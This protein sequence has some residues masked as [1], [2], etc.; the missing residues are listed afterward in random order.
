MEIQRPVLLSSEVVAM[1]PRGELKRIRDDMLD[2][3]LPQI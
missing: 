1:L 2:R 3:Y